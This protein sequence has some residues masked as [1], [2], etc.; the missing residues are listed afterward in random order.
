MTLD[1]QSGCS[2]WLRGSGG[3][4]SSMYSRVMVVSPVKP[5]AAIALA[6]EPR[7][8]CPSSRKSKGRAWC[9]RVGG[10]VR[11]GESIDNQ[12]LAD[13]HRDNAQQ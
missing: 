4:S 13:V 7:N 11:E 9:R 10:T 5:R 2:D 1:T 12:Q 6:S 3:A 8:S